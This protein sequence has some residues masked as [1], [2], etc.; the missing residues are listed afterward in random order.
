MPLVASALT[1]PEDLCVMQKDRDEY[2][3]VAACV[4]A[5]SYWQLPEKIGLSLSQIHA[6]VPGL[7][8]A[9]AE[10]MG[11]FFDKLPA[12]RIFTRRNW[13]IHNSS[14][15]FQPAPEERSQLR[16]LD[17]AKALMMRSET[18]TLR[19]LSAAVVVF[20]I[21]IECHPLAAISA[22]PAAA[23]ALKQALLSRNKEERVAASQDKYQDAVLQLLNNL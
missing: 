7:N 23:L 9:L 12:D 3:L 8:N 21:N 2:Q 17:Q 11:E 5:P 16:T 4:C 20:T 18:Q 14:E 15:R 1:V 19:R 13:L 6:P 10:R 22:Y